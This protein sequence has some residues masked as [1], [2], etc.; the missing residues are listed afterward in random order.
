M[1]AC[2]GVFVLCVCVCVGGGGGGGGGWFSFSPLCSFLASML[3]TCTCTCMY[4]IVHKERVETNSH[5]V[6]V[7]F[8]PPHLGR[9]Q[10]L[11]VE[12]KHYKASVCVV[13]TMGMY[14]YINLT[15]PILYLT[16]SD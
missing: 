2:V 11:K 9:Q 16:F 12:Q 4:F 6:I 1:Y 3:Y 8:R 13:R 10:D 14:V 5:S 7:H 15:L